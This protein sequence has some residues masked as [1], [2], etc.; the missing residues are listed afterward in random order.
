MLY[1]GCFFWDSASAKLQVKN[2]AFKISRRILFL[3]LPLIFCGLMFIPGRAEA[4][5]ALGI[6]VSYYQ[7]SEQNPPTN[8]NWTLVKNSG[9]VTFALVRATEGATYNDPDFVKN[10][11]GA[12]AVG[13]PIGVYHFCLPNSNSPQTEAAH[14]WNIAGSYIKADGKTFIPMLDVETFSGAIVGASSYADWCNQWCEAITNYAYL[15]NNVILKPAIYISA[16]NAGYLNSTVSQ[17][18]P[19]IADYNGESPQTGTPWSTCASDDVWGS[20]F[21]TFWQY[22]S[23]GAVPGIS[24]NMDL[25]VYNGSLS[26]LLVKYV[27]GDTNYPNINTQPANI[28]VY[29]GSNA[30]LS[31]AFA[32]GTSYT[33]QWTF[34]GTNTISGATNATY[35]ITDAQLANAGNYTVT[36]SN[37]AGT[38]TSSQGYLSVLSPIMN[39]PAAIVAPA[40]LVNWYAADGNTRDI[41]G[42]NFGVPTGNMTYAPGEIGQAFHLDGNTAYIT[43]GLA[44]LAVPWTVSVWVNKQTSPQTSAG[45]LEDGTYGL[46]LEQNPNTHEVG[47]TISGVADYVFNPTT[48]YTIP[49]NTWTH[50]AF[51]GTSS[52]VSFYA[53]GV[54]KG[55]LTNNVPLPRNFIGAAYYSSSGKTVDYALGSIDELMIF[56]KALTVAQIGSIY[57]AGSNGLIEGPE[58]TGGGLNASGNLTLNL[59]GQTG[60]NYTIYSSTNLI[61]WVSAGTLANA[62]GTNV[63]TDTGTT[64][65][66]QK[67]YRVSQS[68]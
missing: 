57:S 25:D 50:L 31:V 41:F 1:S 66:A 21:W 61:N 8:I 7:G 68:Y 27:S 3:W 30:T 37:S 13:I 36:I 26:S 32:A 65:N 17:W 19:V 15:S 12:K 14:F 44:D 58:I 20:G 45:L 2:H 29:A 22:T 49:N 42:T 54:L 34:N 56:N 55:S 18:V 5:R 67:F 46:K 47:L 64:N 24:G 28:A 38:V 39:S 33:L 4:Q 51:V 48:P 59:A 10:I 16:C 40:G 63:Y 52:G 35:T 62:A 11:T 60:K 6:D 9:Q 23:S 43:T 53:N